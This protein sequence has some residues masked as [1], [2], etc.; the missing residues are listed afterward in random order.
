MSDNYFLD[1]NIFVDSL[2]PL[3]PPKAR[4]AE[5]LVMRGVDSRLGVISYQVVHE[6]MNVS[7][8]QFRTTMTVIELELYFFK[9][10]LPMMTIPSSSG[11]FLE[12]LRMQKAHQIAWYD[13]LSVAA[14]LQG[15][16][17][18]LYSEDLQH[19]RRFGDL[20]VQNLFS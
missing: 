4:I 13:S 3:D 14:A 18:V 8:R 7:L 19:G 16:C 15:Q 12:A 10:L 20:V 2:D 9:V 1:T 11:L 5:G 6:F 17:R